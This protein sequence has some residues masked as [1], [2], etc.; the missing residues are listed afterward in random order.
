MT[1]LWRPTKYTPE[2]WERFCK[3]L[4]QGRSLRSICKEDRAPDWATIYARIAKHEAFLKQYEKAKEDSADAMIEDMLYIADGEW[5]EDCKEQTQ[6]DR[7]RVDTRKRIASKLKA[8]KYGD[9]IQTEVSGLN[10]WPIEQ[11]T[12]F[13]LPDNER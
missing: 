13:R 11:I 5:V 12:T 2:L 3:E 1:K 4:A 10:G 9:K 6:R 8:K 7:L